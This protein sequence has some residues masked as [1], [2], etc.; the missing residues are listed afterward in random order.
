MRAIFVSL[1]AVGFALSFVGPVQAESIRDAVRHAV[2]T[3]PLV[4]ARDANMKASAYELLRLRGEYLPRVEIFGDIGR[5]RVDDPTSL[6]VATENDVTKT[7]RQIGVRASYVLFDGFRRANL[8]YAN[9]AR[10]DASIFSLLDASETMAL[11][12]AEAY[13]DVYRH[14]ALLEVARRNVRKHISIGQQVRD[15]VEAGRLPFSD[16]LTIDDRIAAARLVELDVQRSLRDAHARYVR[17]IGRAPSGNMSL[18]NVKLPRSEQALRE[19]ALTNSYR[20]KGA[21]ARLDQTTY[22]QGI[23]QA[24]RYPQLTLDVGASRGENRNGNFNTRNDQFAGISMSWTLYK[25]G[26]NDER[27]AFAQRSYEAAFQRDAAARD[28]IDLSSRSWTSLQTNDERARRL[29]QQLGINRSLVDVYREEFDAAKRTLLDLLEI[30]RSRFNVEFEKV[31]ADAS[32]AFSKYRVLA[33]QSRLAEHFGLKPADIALEPTFQR[34]ALASPT[35]VFNTV[36]EPL[37]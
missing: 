15:L 11:N 25:G 5:E 2:T 21:Q 37:E 9:A 32:L 14:Q 35:S 27:R 1:A 36:I 30:E 10:V 31:S 8:V 19:A 4:Q 18:T 23:S 12:A 22:Q 26:R 3:N 20:L 16:E 33:T 13:I 6:E 34:R 24:D 28:V 17:V 7:R 29:R